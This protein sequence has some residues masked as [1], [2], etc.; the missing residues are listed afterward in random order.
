M[1]HEGFHRADDDTQI[2]YGWSGDGDPPLVLCDGIGCDGFI[3][4]YIIDRFA[5]SHRIVRWHYRG[6]G[7]S[8][9]PSDL[10]RLSMQDVVTDLEGV[11]ERLELG[12][13]VLLGHSMGVQVILEFYRHRPDLV[14]GLVPI[15]GAPGRPADSFYGTDKLRP[16]FDHFIKL[17]KRAPQVA[18]VLWTR[19]LP[20][21]LSMV[22]ARY[23]ELNRHL[24]KNADF[25]P[26]LQHIGE[27]DAEIFFRMLEYLIDHDATD[28]LPDIDVPTLVIAGDSDGFTPLACS[29]LMAEQLAFGELLVLEGGT[30]TAPIELPD[31][32]EEAL[33]RFLE[34]L[35]SDTSAPVDAAA[36]RISS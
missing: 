18:R 2:W 29:E 26:Y 17:V 23:T 32:V 30:H 9:K 33:D 10:S 31:L 35:P 11:I 8:A 22:I 34:A 5:P 12:P 36:Q 1:R 15:C 13:V 24:V 20:T 7:R 28:L 6:H 25:W 19:L 3:W 4:P 16:V 14:C 21:R 27:M